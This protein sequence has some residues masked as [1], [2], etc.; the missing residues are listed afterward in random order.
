MIKMWLVGCSTLPYYF[1]STGLNAAQ[2][3]AQV[4]SLKERHQFEGVTFE[5]NV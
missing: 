4:L 2:F 5:H 1:F 3:E